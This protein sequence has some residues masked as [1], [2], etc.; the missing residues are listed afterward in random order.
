MNKSI[1]KILLTLTTFLI[2]IAIW[3]A[4]VLIFNIPVH[5]LPSPFSFFSQLVEYFRADYIY[6]H[7]ATTLYEICVGFLIGTI[8]GLL[9]GYIVAKSRLIERMITPYMVLIQT[10][11][12][13]SIAPLFLLWFGLG[14]SSKIALVIVVVFFPIMINFVV[15]IRSVD[16]NMQNL[17]TIL[18]V[19]RWIKFT[20]IELPNSL[21]FVMSG[22]KASTT[23][24]I[25]GAVIGE[26]IGA[27]SG[28]GYLL[29]LGSETYDINL[30][31]TAV[32]TLSFIGLILYLILE[33]LEK[34]LIH[35]NKSEG[36][37]L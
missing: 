36:L 34:K 12:K 28:L 6:S 18:R 20:S 4:Y 17:L 10:I 13:I 33:F 1:Q 25:T 8:L 24:A 32:L 19:N 5:V 31:L 29:T 7:I 26:L 27:Q 9:V 22:I 2:F 35:W 30:I 21:P 14:V 16:K 37:N 15:G 11:P 23:Y 3:Q